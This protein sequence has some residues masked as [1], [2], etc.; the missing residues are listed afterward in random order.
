MFHNRSVICYIFI[1]YVSLQSFVMITF[2]LY[3]FIKFLFELIF[4]SCINHSVYICICVYA[5]V[6]VYVFV[7]PS[8]VMI[9]IFISYSRKIS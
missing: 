8:N 6:S 9:D 3:N 4:H 2:K 1:M 5:F 7:I